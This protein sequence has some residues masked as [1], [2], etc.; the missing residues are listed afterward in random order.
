M[1]PRL[2]CV[3]FL[4]ARRSQTV[5][6]SEISVLPAR[7]Q[8]LRCAILPGMAQCATGTGVVSIDRFIYK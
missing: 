2:D 1:K 8:R 3:H 5:G 4:F 6:K 7:N